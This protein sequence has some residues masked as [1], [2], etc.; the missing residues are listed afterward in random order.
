MSSLRAGRFL[1]MK[2]SELWMIDDLPI[3]VWVARVPEGSV[4]YSNRSFH[5]ILGMRAVESS[6]LGD[7]PVTYR[8]HDAAGNA[9]PVERLPFSGALATGERV[10]VDDMVIHRPD[11][12]RVP[13]RAFGHPVK[14]SLGKVT[15]V[16]VAFI[17]IT[18]GSNAG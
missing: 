16:I 12:K 14:N 5:E 4:V 11:G 15:H 3:G 17:D 1:A 18:N 2:D 7:V 6:V 13:L 9:Y 8:V 10:A